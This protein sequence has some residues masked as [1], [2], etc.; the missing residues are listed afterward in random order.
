MSTFLAVV[1]LIVAAGAV[2]IGYLALTVHH[3][4]SQEAQHLQDQVDAHDRLRWIETLLRQ[5][6]ELQR[7]QGSLH[8][9][10]FNDIQMAMRTALAIGGLWRQLPVT[11]ILA[12]RPFSEDAANGKPGWEPFLLTVGAVRD[13]L[14]ETASAIGDNASRGSP[15]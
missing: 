11:T 14:F 12:Q 10:E 9:E 2:W 15:E 13:E 3:H 4:A 6:R 5:L 1:G 8:P 7:A